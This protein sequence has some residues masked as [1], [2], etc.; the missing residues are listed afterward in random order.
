MG[1]LLDERQRPRH[2]R[3]GVPSL[4]P[5][6]AHAVLPEFRITEVKLLFAQVRNLLAQSQSGVPQ[7][8]RDIRLG[9]L[10]KPYVPYHIAE[11]CVQFV[12]STLS[13][14]ATLRDSVTLAC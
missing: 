12:S 3:V 9:S 8:M 4:Q 7:R 14:L 13:M 2:L 11:Q 1:E 6:H 10:P 5:V